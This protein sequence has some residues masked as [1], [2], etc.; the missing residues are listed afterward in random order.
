MLARPHPHGSLAF[1]FDDVT[2]RLR[3]EQ[4]FRHSVD[5][6]RATLDRLDEGLAVF[7]PD[8]LL[9]L[10]NEAFHDIW[11]TDAET[12]RPAM[13]AGEIIPLVRGLTVETRVWE[14]LLSFVTGSGARQAWTARLTL[15]PIP[16]ATRRGQLEAAIR[17][18][19][20]EML[21]ARTLHRG[22]GPARRRG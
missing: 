12:V 21:H 2:E 17:R 18:M 10:V 14:R 1:V 19:A 22:P 16:E 8:G 6:R 20:A 15:A 7:G 4:Q 3:L 9:Q 11:G 5:L 13:H